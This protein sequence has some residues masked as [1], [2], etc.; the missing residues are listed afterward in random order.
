MKLAI[1]LPF[2]PLAM[3]DLAGLDTILLGCTAIYE[4]L[5]DPQYAPPTLLKKMVVAGWLGVKTGKGFY[6]YNQ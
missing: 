2:G 3:M 1:G 4:E 5:K 6:E